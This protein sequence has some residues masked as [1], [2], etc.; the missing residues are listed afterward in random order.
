MREPTGGAHRNPTQMAKRL[1]AVLLN[2]LDALDALSTEELL[3]QRYK[4][5]RSYGTY[6]A[7]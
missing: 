2:E 3:D 6:E 5:L 1:K 7:A 4:R